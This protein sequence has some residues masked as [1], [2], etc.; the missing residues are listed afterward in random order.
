MPTSLLSALSWCDN[1]VSEVL[2]PFSI[3]RNLRLKELFS[4]GGH[5]ASKWETSIQ[6]QVCLF[7]LHITSLNL[8]GN[9]GGWPRL[10]HPVLCM[11][12]IPSPIPALALPCQSK[13]VPRNILQGPVSDHS[14]LVRGVRYQISLTTSLPFWCSSALTRCL[15]PW[16]SKCGVYTSST[17]TI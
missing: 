17:S 5:T 9:A 8:Q 3:K 11:S 4:S 13:A 2:A 6:Q 12:F 15:G 16:Y 7:S 1:M 10:P 14:I